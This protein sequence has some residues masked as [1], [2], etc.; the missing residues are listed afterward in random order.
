MTTTT[1]PTNGFRSQRQFQ[2]LVQPEFISPEVYWRACDGFNA[3][4]KGLQTDIRSAES[5]DLLSTVDSGRKAEWVLSEQMREWEYDVKLASGR[6]TAD[7]AIDID[8]EWIGIEAKS[9]RICKNR[10]SFHG[11]Q[12]D[13]SMATIIMFIRP[14]GLECRIANTERLCNWASKYYKYI[15]EGKKSGYSIGYNAT[16]LR[17]THENGIEIFR[18]MTKENVEKA[19]YDC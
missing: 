18:P 5:Q 15:T 16:T 13:K 10:Y 12:P 9:A 8:N 19:I 7:F 14:E 11:I 17:N 1:L 3:E 2:S 6:D 4:K